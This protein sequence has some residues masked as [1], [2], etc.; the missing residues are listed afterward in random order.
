MLIRQKCAQCSDHIDLWVVFPWLLHCLLYLNFWLK[1]IWNFIMTFYIII[2]LKY[3]FYDLCFSQREPAST[4]CIMKKIIIDGIFMARWLTSC[5]FEGQINDCSDAPTTDITKMIA[6]INS[7]K[8]Q[9]THNSLNL[10]PKT[11]TKTFE[12]KQLVKQNKRWSSVITKK[13]PF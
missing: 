3:D 9:T 2:N 13:S 12:I 8:L 7:N 6:V 10:L 1:S 5:L 11:N 4:T